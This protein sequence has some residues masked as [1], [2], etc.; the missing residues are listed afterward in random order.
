[1][2][3]VVQ[4]ADPAAVNVVFAANAEPPTARPARAPA[5]KRDRFA[6]TSA[7]VKCMKLLPL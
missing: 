4:R 5:S 7:V 2:P 1:L 3:A 6:A